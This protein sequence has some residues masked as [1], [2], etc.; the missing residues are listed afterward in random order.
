MIHSKQGPS[1]V[2]DFVID[3]WLALAVALQDVHH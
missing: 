1:I 2:F 3:A